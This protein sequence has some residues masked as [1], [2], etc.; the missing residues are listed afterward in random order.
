VGVRVEDVIVVEENGGRKINE[1]TT[2]LL[3]N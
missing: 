1:F 2:E 3:A